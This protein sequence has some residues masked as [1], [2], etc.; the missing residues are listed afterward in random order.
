MEK[1]RG[2]RKKPPLMAARESL[3]EYIRTCQ[4]G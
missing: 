3:T 4:N 2:Q 1:S